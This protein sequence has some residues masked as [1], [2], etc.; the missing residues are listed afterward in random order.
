M[1]SFGGEGLAGDILKR[2]GDLDSILSL[3]GGDK[4]EG[5]A[6]VGIRGGRVDHQGTWKGRN[7]V[8][9][10]VWRWC[11]CGLQSERIS[12]GQSAQNQAEKGYD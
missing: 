1:Y 6:N 7:D 12:D 5:I 11:W 9:S 3:L 8:L 10:K 2:F 4:V